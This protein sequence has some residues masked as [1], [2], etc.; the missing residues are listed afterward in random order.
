MGMYEGKTLKQ[1]RTMDR[2][3]MGNLLL[4]KLEAQQLL[5]KQIKATNEE[6]Q[7]LEPIVT[8]FFEYKNFKF[9]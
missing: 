9:D 1:L 8:E 6:G 2:G 5:N 4:A 3:L 7:P